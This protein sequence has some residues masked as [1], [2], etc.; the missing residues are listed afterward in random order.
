[1]VW[2]NTNATRLKRWFG[3]R[4]IVSYT[5]IAANASGVAFAI[6]HYYKEQEDADHRRQD[7]AGGACLARPRGRLQQRAADRALRARA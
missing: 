1:M 5:I 2:L 7:Q 3:E 6:R 4:H